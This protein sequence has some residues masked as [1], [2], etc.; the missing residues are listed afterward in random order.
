[1][2]PACAAPTWG[3]SA[4]LWALTYTSEETSLVCAEAGL[5]ADIGDAQISPGW[6]ALRVAGSL[7]FS[8]VGILASLAAPLAAAG[9]SIFA[10]STYDTDYLL[11]RASDLARAIETLSGEGHQ[12]R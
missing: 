3:R 7:D 1:M 4:G 5:P 2:A 6:R 9:V 11:V 8:L 12:I 10:I